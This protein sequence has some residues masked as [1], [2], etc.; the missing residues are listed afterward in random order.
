MAGQEA[1]DDFL[2]ALER[3]QARVK[4]P[5]AAPSLVGGALYEDVKAGTGWPKGIVT[6]GRGRSES[7]SW[8]A[9]GARGAAGAPQ[10]HPQGQKPPQQRHR[11]P[12]FE[13]KLW[14]TA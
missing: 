6:R 7:V 5:A 10:G 2:E 9:R 4:N 14:L 13:G 3:P 1:L 12:G 8:P 11:Q